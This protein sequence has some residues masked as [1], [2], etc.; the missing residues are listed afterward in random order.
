MFPD[1]TLLLCVNLQSEFVAFNEPQWIA[2]GT[3][4][5]AN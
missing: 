1:F 3:A 2:D 5:P 4:Q